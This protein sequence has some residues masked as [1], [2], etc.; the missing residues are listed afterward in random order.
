MKSDDEL[1]LSLVL[2]HRIVPVWLR[3]ILRS[4]R[5]A[6]H[7]RLAVSVPTDGL[8]SGARGSIL[9]ESWKS[10]DARA[11]RGR[12]PADQNTERTADIGG[13]LDAGQIHGFSVVGLET[14]AAN[15]LHHGA[16]II[17]WMAPGR[18]PETLISAAQ[19]GVLSVADAFNPALGFREIVNREAATACDVVCFGKTSADDRILARTY[20]A[21]DHLSL[22]RG[23]VG[24]RAKCQALLLST[25]TRICRHDVLKRT[26][27][28]PT[29]ADRICR[30]DPGFLQLIWSLGK[31]YGR[32]CVDVIKR[33]FFFDQWQIAY[34]VGGDRLSQDDM[35]KL[36]PAH[37][38]FWADPFVAERDGRKFI[39]FEELLQETSRGH[40]SAIE[41]FPDG[42]VGTPINVL[43]REYHFSYPFLFDYD[44]ALYM[45]PEC[46]DAGRVEVFRCTRFPDQWEP[47][48]VLLDGVRAFDPTLIEHDGRW[49][50]FVT[51]QHGGNSADDELHLYY[52][53]D[54][55][56]EWIPHPLNPIRLDVR[57]A[58]PAG[59][60]FWQEGRLYRPAQ[61]CSTR[62]GWAI[63]I[64]EVKC[65]T[66]RDYREVEAHRILPDWATSAH[67]THTINQGNGVT[68]YDCESKCRK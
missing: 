66:T 45:V 29:A 25:V 14:I 38:G 41:I 1:K 43:Q 65:M 27:S 61:D 63:A 12:I 3:D 33:S 36:A 5:D 68:V 39:F 28:T 37:R 7:I 54:P 24:V 50:M 21:S 35:I 16:D 57:S 20:A 56:D 53:S 15:V 58:R 49:W 34:R 31:L 40:I 51:I 10:L 42:L 60:L 55:F 62:Y 67:A 6:E 18:P 52:A 8:L 2:P 4:L 26:Q 19:Y 13:E 47:H 44:G 23:M 22:A 30:R 46:A 59:S 9:F 64:Q 32:Y 11:F 48:A 17:V